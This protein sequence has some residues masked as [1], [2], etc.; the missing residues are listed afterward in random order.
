[1][2]TLRADVRVIHDAALI[3][4]DYRDSMFRKVLVKGG[5]EMLRAIVASATVGVTAVVMLPIGMQSAAADT[6]PRHWGFV[7]GGI[8]RTDTLNIRTGRSTRYRIVHT[9]HYTEKTKCYTKYCAGYVRGASYKCP[10]GEKDNYWLPVYWGH[11]KRW[12]AGQC[13]T[14]G[15]RT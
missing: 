2:W 11:K 1:M 8:R 15:Y 12:V 6:V 7:E 5:P 4:N 13:A 14:Y 9:L 10:D 3:T